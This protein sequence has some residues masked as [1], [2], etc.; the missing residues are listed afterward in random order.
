MFRV[1][2]NLK[3]KNYNFLTI[4]AEPHQEIERA[5]AEDLCETAQ[6]NNPI[7]NR[8]QRSYWEDE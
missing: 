8:K 7:A 4:D 3:W 5:R 6:T 1:D 2:H